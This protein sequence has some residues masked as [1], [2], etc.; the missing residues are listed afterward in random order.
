MN[1]IRPTMK[2]LITS[3]LLTRVPN[4]GRRRWTLIRK[5]YACL[6]TVRRLPCVLANY[7]R[8]MVR[9]REQKTFWHKACDSLLTISVLP[10]NSKLYR[11]NCERRTRIPLQGSNSH[12]FL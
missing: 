2:S 8:A 1:G 4:G 11:E 12:A 7:R 10:R 3:E 5:R 9:C 6:P